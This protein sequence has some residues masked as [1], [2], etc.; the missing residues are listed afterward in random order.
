MSARPR[1]PQP[2][3]DPAMDSAYFRTFTSVDGSRVLEDLEFSYTPDESRFADGGKFNP[4]PV[5]AAFRDGCREVISQI[6][7][8]IKRAKT[9]PH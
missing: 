6:R 8:A 3:F 4:C 2:E 1:K 5:R 9:Q 7:R